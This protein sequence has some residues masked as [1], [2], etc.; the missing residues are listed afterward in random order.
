MTVIKLQ[1]RETLLKRRLR[2]HFRALGFEKDTDGF[3]LLPDS[4]KETY[5][6]LHEAQRIEK[7]NSNK[8]FIDQNA[9]SLLGYLASGKDVDPTGIRPRLEL[10]EGG[11]W[12][13]NL[14][15]FVTHYWS[16][17]VSEGYGRRMRFLV[18]DD[19]NDKLIGVIALG[20]A[21]FNLR[22]R[23]ELVGWNHEQRKDRMANILDAYVLGA[24]P[25]YN[26]L[27]GGKLVASLIKTKEVVQ[28]FKTKY[29]ESIGIISG[30]KKCPNL[31]LV[32]TTSSMGRSS[33]YNRLK[34]EN[35]Q[36]LERVGFTSGWGHFHIPDDIF[37]LMRT[38]LSEKGDPYANNHGFGQ[39]PNW[40]LRAIR[41]T[42]TLLGM[43]NNLARHGLV[44]EVFVSHIAKNSIPFLM[45]EATK[46]DFTALRSV[47]EVAELA[48]AR[49]IIPRAE[50]RPE[51]RNWC[52]E[53]FPQTFCADQAMILKSKIL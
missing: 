7:F 5:R 52:A 40:R 49:W 35:E 20:D 42:F 36:F 26:F 45:G 28:A 38:Y 15:R 4:S 1:A 32:T 8:Q 47:N 46:P 3:L 27:L 9:K 22:A 34:L 33:V 18:W 24:V 23:D 14:F 37:E 10:I 53:W 29:S 48:L 21:V 39:G 19:A 2:A 13:S 51:Y 11:T 31:V 12:Q 43:N 17:P 6:K 16:V 30:K 25:P 44:R 50:R 41:K